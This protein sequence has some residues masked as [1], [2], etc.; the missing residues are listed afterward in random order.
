MD[1]VPM[2][3]SLVL[4]LTTLLGAFIFYSATK[5]S[6][7]SLMI[8]LI[9]L[10]I[11]SA[12]ALTGLYQVTKESLPW[13]ILMSAPPMLLIIGMFMSKKG[14]H[15]IDGLNLKYLTLLHIIRIP[16]EIVLYWLCF[17]KTVPV[18]MTFEGRNFDILSGSAAPL[19]YYFGFIKKSISKKV[20]LVWNFIC[21]G[22]LLNIVINAILSIPLPFQKF[23]FDQPNIAVLYF[24]FVWL[25]CFIVPVVLFAHLSAIR[26]LRMKEYK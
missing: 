9:W 15:F 24:P 11:Q 14:T 25:P 18:L 7:Q 3:V 19:I 10:A 23:G 2:Y 12:I 5:N 16:V 20:I 4:V 17:Y 6:R 21:I 8:I 1:Q 26:L 13:P 22:L